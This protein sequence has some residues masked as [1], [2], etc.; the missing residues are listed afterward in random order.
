[1]EKRKLPKEMPQGKPKEV[2]PTPKKTK[3][4]RKA[5]EDDESSCG[6]AEEM[7]LRTIMVGTFPIY[8]KC[9]TIS[10]FTIFLQV[11]INGGK[12]SGGIERTFS[13]IGKA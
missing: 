5:T 12:P 8:L 11:K 2:R 3:F 7:D 1:M 10:N 9:S 13:S 4:G 6:S